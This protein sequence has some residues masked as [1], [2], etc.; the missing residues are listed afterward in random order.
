M[1]NDVIPLR[2]NR[3]FSISMAEAEATLGAEKPRRA[4]SYGGNGGDGMDTTQKDYVDARLDSVRAQNDARFAEVI[5]K[6]E[7][8]PS[9]G[10]MAAMIAGATV[11]IVGL[12]VGV[13][14]FGGDR[15]DGGI[16]AADIVV[17]SKENANQIGQLIEANRDR[18]RKIDA[19]LT[20]LQERASQ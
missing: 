5:A 16:S 13:L 4:Y 9:I 6:L 7:K 8:M 10:A 18:D 12:I 3:D 1:G 2:P 20:I 17:Q 11:T 15:F 19:M 14:A